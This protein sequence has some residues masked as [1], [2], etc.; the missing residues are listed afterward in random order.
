[1]D[2]ISHVHDTPQATLTL[3]LNPNNPANTTLLDE[4]GNTIYTIRTL[5]DEKGVPTTSVHGEN[6]KRVADWRWRDARLGAQMLRFEGAWIGI[7]QIQ[8]MNEKGKKTVGGGGKE[9]VA[10]S[11]W[12]RKSPIPF[13]S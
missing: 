4:S 12:L 10:A 13:K 5:F 8:T 11:R 1:M 7:G 6:G 9:R 2:P 3:T